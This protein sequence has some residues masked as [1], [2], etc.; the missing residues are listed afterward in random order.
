[1]L[2][3]WG[4]RSFGN[5]KMAVTARVPHVDPHV[6]YRQ[7]QQ[8]YGFRARKAR[9]PLVLP[10]SVAVS[11]WSRFRDL[12]ATTVRQSGDR[13]VDTIRS[14]NSIRGW[15]NG[16][17]GLGGARERAPVVT[18]A[19]L[20]QGTTSGDALC[21]ALFCLSL[22]RTP[23]RVILSIS[24]FLCSFLH[25]TRFTACVFAD[26]HTSLRTPDPI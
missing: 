13:S 17:H 7:Y 21:A 14:E 1:M 19:I 22:V 3:R 4:T 18:V 8:F 12:F 11:R 26:G 9:S 20:A 16:R 24:L 23:G 5:R 10:D 6:A 2:W 15:Q 25:S